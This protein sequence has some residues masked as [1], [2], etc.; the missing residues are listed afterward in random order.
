MSQDLKN[1]L[2]EVPREIN[3][4]LASLRSLVKKY[5]SETT[6]Q[7]FIETIVNMLEKDSS[8]DFSTIAS[9]F[10]SFNIDIISHIA[11]IVESHLINNR[12]PLTPQ[13]LKLSSLTNIDPIWFLAAW[14]AFNEDHPKTSF[15]LLAKIEVEDKN[16][17]GMKGQILL[18]QG[19]IK[20]SITQFQKAIRTSPD[21]PMLWFQLAKAHYGNGDDS[22]ALNSIDECLI[23]QPD[24][25][26]CAA[27]ILLIISESEQVTPSS[28]KHWKLIEQNNLGNNPWYVG[29][30]L[31]AAV[32]NNNP[33]VFRNTIE[34]SQWE[35]LMRDP[36]FI[37]HLPN[38]LREL[39]VDHS[40]KNEQKLFLEAIT[41]EQKPA[42]S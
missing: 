35:H 36:K 12:S 21:D 26:E 1:W 34:Q 40:W 2:E 19:Y 7:D 38:I 3:T 6:A 39:S 25:Q 41:Q 37:E 23:L 32:Q 5:L 31:T 27:F 20:Q 10:L 33:Q 24:N 30:L 9:F 17:L 22:L 4:A 11:T 16:T 15:E 28:H 42:I 8:I 29:K 14:V 18:E 13:I